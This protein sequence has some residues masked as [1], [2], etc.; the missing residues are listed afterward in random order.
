MTL[1]AEQLQQKRSS[2]L[3]IALGVLWLVLGAAHFAYQLANPTVEVNWETATEMQ[4]AGFNLYRSST[5]VGDFMLLNQ[6]A[7]LIPS[8]GEGLTG[9]SYTYIDDS[10][11]VGNTYY[12]LLEEVEFNQN[13]NRY[14]DDLF[15]YTVPY[16]TIWTAVLTAVSV[17]VGLALLVTG[18][19]EDRNL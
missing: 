16:V 7:G 15:A 18:L 14:E 11:D 5:P 2:R 3:F 8:Q 6:E 12:Y 17:V 9:A 4:T 1:E 10:V 13:V 19:R